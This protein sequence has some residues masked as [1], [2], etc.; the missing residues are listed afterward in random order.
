MHAD[1]KEETK[2]YLNEVTGRNVNKQKSIFQLLAMN[3][4]K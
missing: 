1:W 2:L 4:W 3:N